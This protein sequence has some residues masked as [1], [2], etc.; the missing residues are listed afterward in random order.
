VWSAYGPVYIFA[1]GSIAQLLCA[2]L[3]LAVE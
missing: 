1:V 3:V 2:L